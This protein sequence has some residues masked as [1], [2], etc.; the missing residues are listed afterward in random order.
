MLLAEFFSF[1]E[2]PATVGIV[3]SMLIPIAAILGAFWHATRKAESENALKQS[4]IERGY[5][6]EEIERVLSARSGSKR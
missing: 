1:L 5:S 3:M 2:N 6:P 4:M